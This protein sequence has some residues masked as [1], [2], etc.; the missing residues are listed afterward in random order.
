VLKKLFC[1]NILIFFRSNSLDVDRNHIE[2][3]INWCSNR[4][5]KLQD[6]LKDDFAFLWIK[7]NKS[8][9]IDINEEKLDQ[10]IIVLENV[11]FEKEKIYEALKQFSKENDI[12]FPKFMRMLR[13]GLTGLS[14]GPGVSEMM[15]ILGKKTSIERISLFKNK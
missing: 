5:T 1:K 2:K 4:I 11:R 8:V 7:P 14:D 13:T 6:L 3:V 10:L 12:K 15:E 9:G